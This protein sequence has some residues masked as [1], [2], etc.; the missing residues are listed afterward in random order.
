MADEFADKLNAVL[1]NPE[2]MG[3]IMS[4]ARSL[5]GDSGDEG[6]SQPPIQPPVESMPAPASP[7]SAAPSTQLP[8]L[9][10]IMNM[11]GRSH[12]RGGA[13]RGGGHLQSP[14]PLWGIW[15]P[16]SCRPGCGCSLSWAAPTTGNR[17]S[18]RPAPLCQR[19]ALRQSRP[20]HSGCKTVPCDPG[21]LPALQGRRRT[22]ACITDIS[23]TAQPI[24]VFRRRTRLRSAIPV[25]K[26]V[27]YRPRSPA[28]RRKRRRPAR[29]R[30]PAMMGG[31]PIR[32]ISR[33]SS[34]RPHGGRRSAIKSPPGSR[35]S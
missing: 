22:R 24:P 12:G 23:Q 16:G 3:Q 9:S 19:G 31:I 15:T 5:T 7:A 34:R 21:G 8:D 33:D 20:R 17:S 27:P 2:A 32:S 29:R 35:D 18:Y 13:S 10:G 25:R 30:R 4:L 26:A 6:G 1:G 11:A 14:W 28:V